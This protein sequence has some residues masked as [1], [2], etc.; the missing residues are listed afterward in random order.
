MST[1]YQAYRVIKVEEKDL[2]KFAPMSFENFLTRVKPY[3]FDSVEAF[4]L[5]WYRGLDLGDSVDEW[6]NRVYNTFLLS[7]KNEL[8]VEVEISSHSNK[9]GDI[10]DEIDG[11]Y[12]A[13]SFDTVYTLTP[14]A[15]ALKDKGLDFNFASFVSYG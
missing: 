4:Y 15:Q 11:V 14:A 5:Q 1:G 6:L 9:D 2:Q 3:G 13:L 7:L 10:Y 8:G 12:F